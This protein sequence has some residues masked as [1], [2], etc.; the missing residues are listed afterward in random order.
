MDKGRIQELLFR[1]DFFSARE[2]EELAAALIG[3]PTEPEAIT[4]ALRGIETGSYFHGLTTE[5]LVGLLC[6]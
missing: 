6:E 1:G 3:L 4:A 5:D 2:P